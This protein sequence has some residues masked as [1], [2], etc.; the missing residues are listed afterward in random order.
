MQFLYSEYDNS[1]RKGEEQRER[2]MGF[3]G[4]QPGLTT[5]QLAKLMQLSEV[6]TKKHLQRLAIEGRAHS[7]PLVKRWRGWYVGKAEISK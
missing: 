6:N 2:L 5:P 3:I 4:E 7:R 1:C